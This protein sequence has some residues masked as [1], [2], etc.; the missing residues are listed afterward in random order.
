MVFILQFVNVVYHTDG[1]VDIEEPLHPWDKSRL[2]MMYNPF[3]DFC[4]NNFCV[5]IHQ[6]YWLIFFF[7]EFV[8][9]LSFVL[10]Y[11]LISFLIF[12]LTHWFLVAC[13]LVSM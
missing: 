1:F 5:Y 2:I 13:C 6:T 3:N 12:S 7:F 4:I 11:F 9:S 8:S 10:R